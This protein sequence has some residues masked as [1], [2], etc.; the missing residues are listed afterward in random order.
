MAKMTIPT[1]FVKNSLGGQL[2]P[3][4]PL[5]TNQIS[6]Y[7]CGITVYDS[8]HLGHIRT[9]VAFDNIVRYLR[10]VGYKVRFVRNITDIDDKIV[11]KCQLNNQTIATLTE[12]YTDLMHRDFR[13]LGMVE[14]DVEPKATRHID[15]IIVMIEQ[16][17]TDG[18]AY[19][20]AGGDVYFKIAKYKD[21]GKLSGTNLDEMLEGFRLEQNDDKEDFKDFALWKRTAEDNY[22]WD[23][24]F[25]RGRPGWHIECSAMSS[26]HLG[27]N[28]DIH[29]GGGDLIFPH[30]ENEL[31]QSRCA[32]LGSQFASYWLH[33]GAVRIGGD[34]MSKS[35]GNFITA[36]QLL[37]QYHPEVLRFYIASSHYRSAMTYTD[38]ALS[39]VKQG[40]DRFYHCLK[41]H[42]PAQNLSDED[43]HSSDWYRQFCTAM[44]KDFNTSEALATLF[45]LV[46]EINCQNSVKQAAIL[47][48]I[49]QRLAQ[50]MGLLCD[51]PQNYL[52]FGND[53]H[54]EQI[55]QLIAQRQ[56]ARAEKDF[57]SADAIRDK[58]LAMNIVLEDSR[59]GIQWRSK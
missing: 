7:L 24:P 8:C 20:T 26:K 12:H 16:L 21:Y 45:Q 56:K 11:Q 48:A 14:P 46:Q 41:R 43:F 52:N 32:N 25:G 35:L 59:D 28:F 47:A 34:K 53:Y 58:L 54:A 42:A 29:G 57:A 50:V 22:N 39:N 4:K 13:K 17:L 40:L 36:A 18:F 44:N 23:S 30:H 2:V 33:T 3:L 55:E 27:N 5:V 1:I 37:K 31:A 15:E 38:D 19:K 49:L 9:F 6:M 51:S 10:S